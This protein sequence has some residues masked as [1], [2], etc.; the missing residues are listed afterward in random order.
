MRNYIK[1][2][3]VSLMILF[4]T[5]TS[6]MV[7]SADDTCIINN[8]IETNIGDKVTYN[9]Y[10][11]DVPEK[12]EDLQIEINYNADCLEAVE[13][14][15]T[16]PDGGSSVYNIKI[17]GKV[18]FNSANGIEGWDF[19]KKTLLFG[20][21]FKVTAPGES[22]IQQYIQCMDYLS[23]SQSVDD[24]VLTTEY[25][26]NNETAKEGEPPVINPEGQGGNFVNFENGKGEKNG[27]DT[28]IGGVLGG[29]NNDAN[30]NQ[31]ANA[32]GNDDSNV[33]DNGNVA[34]QEATVDAPEVS[35]TETTVLLTNSSGVEITESN[36]EAKTW[37]ETNDT[38]RNIGIIGFALAIVA[39]IVITVL[40]KKKSSGKEEN[41]KK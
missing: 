7:V 35:T 19:K 4:I 34:G 37:S 9:L 8:D 5:V 40:I 31:A 2:I 23:N 28:P 20:V 29:N 3:S 24:Y 17:P 13:G 36:G 16:Y 26:V 1:A 39:C 14:S 30:V 10:I 11:S 12:V 18:L 15:V 41:S 32:D 6:V 25:L 21:S 27:G 22:D 38:W 33:V